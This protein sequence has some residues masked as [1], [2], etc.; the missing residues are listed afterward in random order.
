MDSTGNCK[1]LGKVLIYIVIVT[2]RGT[3]TIYFGKFE[4]CGDDGVLHEG[5]EPCDVRLI[6]SANNTCLRDEAKS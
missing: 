2:E 5:V 3:S 1:G 6:V 4:Q